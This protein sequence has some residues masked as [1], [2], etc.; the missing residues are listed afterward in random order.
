MN[1]LKVDSRGRVRFAAQGLRFEVSKNG[2][3]IY[4]RGTD[5]LGYKY[6]ESFFA[7]RLTRATLDRIESAD[8]LVHAFAYGI[9]I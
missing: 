3:N 2:V 4:L 7:S 5:G 9:V 1:N 6:E 8:L